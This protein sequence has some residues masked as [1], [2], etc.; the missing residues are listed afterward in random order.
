MAKS[1]P[2]D[3]INA[4]GDRRRRRVGL[5]GG[6]FNPAHQGHLHAALEA[7]VRLGLDEV[8][9]LVSPQNPLKS[10]GDMA[11]YAIRLQSTQALV[12]QYPALKAT[13]IE[14]KL[15][16]RFT[17]DTISELKRRFPQVQFVWLMGA[18]NL[19]QISHWTRWVQLFHMLPVAIVDRPPYSRAVLAAKAA[20]RFLSYRRPHR[21][22]MRRPLPAWTFLHIR[23]HPASATEIRA[24][25][26]L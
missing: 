18:D 8:W 6:S 23:H 2:A 19:F 1:G 24:L 4:W 11:P 15:G 20:R 16:T 5:L 22:L 7:L 12:R 3:P 25:T 9:F 13:G 14:T 26:Q 21:A 10:K 17:V